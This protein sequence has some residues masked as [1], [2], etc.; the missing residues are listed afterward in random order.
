MWGH[1]EASNN[2]LAALITTYDCLNKFYSIYMA[3]IVS[4]AS[5]RGLSIDACHTNQPNKSKLQLYKLLIHFLV[6]IYNSYTQVTRQ[7][8]SVKK[9]DVAYVGR[10][11]TCIK[12]LKI[13]AVV[14][15][16]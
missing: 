15:Y 12:A 16:R 2:W 1:P 14:G 13:R 10:Y 6:V 11:Y 4:I 3:A 9:V 8:T 7:S 5:R